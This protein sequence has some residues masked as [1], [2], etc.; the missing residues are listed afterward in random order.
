[1]VAVLAG[2]RLGEAVHAGLG[3][4]VVGPQVDVARPPVV[5]ADVDDAAPSPL[6]HR[7]E[8][9]VREVEARV[10]VDR[11]HGVPVLDR[12]VLERL[13]APHPDVRHRDVHAAE[14]IGGLADEPLDVLGQGHVR[15]HADGTSA[16]PFDLADHGVDGIPVP[17]TVHHDPGALGGEG[18][19]DRPADVAPGSGHD[20]RAAVKAA[21]I[22]GCCAQ[23]PHPSA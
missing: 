22:T 9:E 7:R 15:D 16:G 18:Q 23:G 2:D 6:P 4:D 12:D 5:P 13:L 10:Q 20:R 11:H 3:C 19:G 8:R 14:R 17:V 1:V 21:S